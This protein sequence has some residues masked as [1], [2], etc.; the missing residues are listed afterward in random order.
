[1][2]GYGKAG[3]FYNYI[4]GATSSLFIGLNYEYSMFSTQIGNT[5]S[6]HTLKN[7]ELNIGYRFWFYQ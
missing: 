6:N 4:I 2:G 1:M 3:I 7:I 5:T